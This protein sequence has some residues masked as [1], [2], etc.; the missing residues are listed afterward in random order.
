MNK[1]LKSHVKLGFRI[2]G[3]ILVFFV[4]YLLLSVLG[5][6]KSDNTQ[7]YGISFVISVFSFFF[8]FKYLIEQISSLVP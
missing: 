8:G 1:K 4:I 6:G 5:I 3:A 2:F 7:K